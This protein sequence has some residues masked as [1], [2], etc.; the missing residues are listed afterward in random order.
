ME[1]KVIRTV[2][3]VDNGTG[4]I[5]TPEQGMRTIETPEQRMPAIHKKGMDF[6]PTTEECSSGTSAEAN[7][8]NDNE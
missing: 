7:Q 4:I 2:E 5:E 3:T 8:S 6:M 1:R